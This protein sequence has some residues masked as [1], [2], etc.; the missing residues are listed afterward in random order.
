MIAIGPDDKDRKKDA[1]YVAYFSE[2]AE[3][4]K[5]VRSEDGGK[6][7]S[8]SSPVGNGAY[9]DLEVAGDG[10]LHATFVGMNGEGPP[11]DRYGDPRNAVMYTQSKD[12]GRSFE[13]PRAVSPT[14]EP[15]PFFFSNPQVAIDTRRKLV[16]VAYPA[17]TPDGRWDI[18]LATSRD[19]GASFSRVKVND[20]RSCANHRTP[21]MALGPTGAVHLVWTENRSGTGGL[22]YARC[23]SGGQKCGPNEAVTDRPM[24]SYSLARFTPRWLGEYGALL[25]DPAAQKL[26]AVFTATT[27]ED[28]KSVARIFAA[29][30]TLD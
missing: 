12:G 25:P 4:M 19:G 23:D 18:F 30:A 16:Y 15:I 10:T 13:K 1:I 3:G 2:A 9:G 29:T 5:L 8:P 24:T 17:G 21:Q 11:P 22:A 14:G 28:G 27:D 6:T 20:D 26:H 7:F